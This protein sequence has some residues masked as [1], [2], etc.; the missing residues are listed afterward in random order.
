MPASFFC[1]AVAAAAAVLFWR[2]RR[3]PG[4]SAAISVGFALLYFSVLFTC[5]LPRLDEL[6]LTRSVADRVRQETG[7]RDATVISVGYT[8]PS[9][10]FTLG[11]QTILD[12]D[13]ARAI[14]ELKR[15][16]TLA[17]VQDA[18]NPLPK[19]LP[20]GDAAWARINQAFSALPKHCHRQAFLDAAARAGMRVREV[21][22]VDGWNYSRTKRMRVILYARE[23]EA[24]GTEF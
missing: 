20:V 15:P 10:A 11:T 24:G 18:P 8:E 13:P 2:F 21:G 4:A 22:S 3:N 5:V 14:R 23:K 6:W 12:A 19:L 7:G 1:A 9:V 16:G 17:L